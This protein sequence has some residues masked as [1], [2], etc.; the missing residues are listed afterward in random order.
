VRQLVGFPVKEQWYKTTVEHGDLKLF[1]YANPEY[2]EARPAILFFHGAGFSTNK[3]KPNQFQS[4]ANHFASLGYVSICVE[5]RPPH[6]QGVF[7]PMD[8][9]LH[10]K[11]AIRW[12][13]NKSMLLGIAPNKITVAGAS[14][15]GYLSLCCAMLEQFN[16]NSDDLAI[17]CVPNAVVVFNGGVDTDLLIK[18]F[19]DLVNPLSHASPMLHI[20]SDLPPTILFHGTLDD[21]VPHDKV[22]DFVKQMKQRNNDCT[23]ISFDGM[24]HGFFNYG[25]HENIPYERTIY[26]TESFLRANMML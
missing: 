13:R 19:P 16:D 12:V 6:I 7:S 15:G 24:G 2:K 4:H 23:L 21:R 17:S 25:Q 26:E 1:I 9:I 22:E 11:S 5:Y 3:V 20:R 10:A 8:C 18:M 14:A